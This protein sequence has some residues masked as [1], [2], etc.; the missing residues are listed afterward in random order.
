MDARFH[1]L[2]IEKDARAP[3]LFSYWLALMSKVDQWWIVGRASHES[4]A[5]CRF[6]RTDPDPRLRALLEFPANTCRVDL[7]TGGCI[8]PDFER[9]WTNSCRKNTCAP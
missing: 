4:V 3:L 5:I 2:L 1:G 8:K 7:E 9:S 6:L